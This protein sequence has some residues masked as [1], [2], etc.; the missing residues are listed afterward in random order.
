MLATSSPEIR[1]STFCGNV[2]ND[3][4][5]PWA[6]RGGTVFPKMRDLPDGNANGLP[7]D[8]DILLGASSDVND[9]GLPD[10]CECP[11]DIDGNGVVDFADLLVVI[12][13]G[14]PCP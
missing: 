4:T 10:E 3:I 2:D 11:A 13:N 7:D 8:L 1:D 6:D 5:G 9:N 14:G 12:A